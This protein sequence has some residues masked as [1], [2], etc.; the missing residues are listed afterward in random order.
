MPKTSIS[1]SLLA[2]F[3]GR[4]RAAAIYGDLTEMAATRSRLWFA[5][6][7]IRTLIALTWRPLTAFFV[8]A[9]L[10][11]FLGDRLTFPVMF[12]F[13]LSYPHIS[14]PFGDVIFV[15]FF[16]VPFA[17]IRYGLRDRVVQLALTFL[18]LAIGVVFL[19]LAWSIPEFGIALGLLAPVSIVAATPWRRSLVP[20]AVSCT[21]GAIVLEASFHLRGFDWAVPGLRSLFPV[22]PMLFAFLA[23]AIIFSWCHRRFQRSQFTGAAHA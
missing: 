11:A 3:A 10:F 21:L 14:E 9:I 6:A 1:E 5:A 4:D 13:A 12:G 22:L 19:G 23:L 15:L 8:G 18:L 16:L 2:L 7:Y 17:A 20:L